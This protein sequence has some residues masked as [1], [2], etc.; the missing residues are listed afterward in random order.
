PDQLDVDRIGTLVPHLHLERHFVILADFI[1]QA[2]CMHEN[3]FL[4]LMIADKAVA[5][6][7]VEKV[8]R[9]SPNRIQRLRRAL[10]GDASLLIFIAY[11]AI[12]CRVWG[13]GSDVAVFIYVPDHLVTR[14]ATRFCLRSPLLPSLCLILPLFA[15]LLF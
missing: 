8:D 13:C 10:P 7:I 6:R 14:S 5:F 9:S 12:F 15:V 3:A 11:L 2:I 1:D 4:G